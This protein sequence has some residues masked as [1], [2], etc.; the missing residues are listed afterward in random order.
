MNT[1][2]NLL[3]NPQKKSL[4]TAQTMAFL[5]SLALFVMLVAL[6]IASLIFSLKLILEHEVESN[7]RQSHSSFE[8]YD[9]LTQ[10]M[11]GINDYIDR[12][13]DVHG[14]FV[15]WSAVLEQLGHA[16][17]HGL[18]F[19]GITIQPDMTLMVEGSAKTRDDVLAME[20]QLNEYPHFIDISSPLSNI[21]QKQNLRFEFRMRFI[22]P[23]QE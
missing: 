11:R 9:L 13:D 19:E 14:H 23:T 17:P 2:L 20:K 12:V 15:D 22:P 10:Q 8:E 18:Q 4:R 7:A 3:P 5:Q 1:T 21:L 6:I 16:A